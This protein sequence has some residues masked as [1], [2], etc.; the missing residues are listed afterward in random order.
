[1]K[2]TLL[3]AAA[4]TT[5]VALNAQ[6]FN[7]T[8]WGNNK[9]TTINNDNTFSYDNE[10][11]TFTVQYGEGVTRSSVSNLTTITLGGDYT[12][13]VAKVV[14]GDGCNF[15]NIN[16]VSPFI[17]RRQLRNVQTAPTTMTE[18]EAFAPYFITNS[19]QNI[20]RYGKDNNQTATEVYYWRYMP[21]LAIKDTDKVGVVDWSKEFALPA[22]FANNKKL[23]LNGEDAWGYSYLDLRLQTDT[24]NAPSTAPSVTFHW[25]EIISPEKLG[26]TS[27]NISTANSGSVGSAVQKY[28]E[29]AL[30]STGIENVGADNELAVSVNGNCVTVAGATAVEA[31]NLAGVKVAQGTDEV[32]VPAG[33][34]VVRATSATGTTVAKVSVK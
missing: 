6:S 10:N 9:S 26:Y 12:V 21:S 29:A 14:Y 7:A 3:I 1:M 30:V 22:S 8:Q 28:I 34:Y 15:S 5:A 32:T 16:K 20:G 25:I 23:S 31:Y 2:K 24:D 19:S 11:N 33:I 27:E 4:A 18:S 17:V 13:F